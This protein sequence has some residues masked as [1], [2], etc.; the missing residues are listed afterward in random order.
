M[1][2]R[3]RLAP[4]FVLVCLLAPGAS[5]AQA[6]A[7]YSLSVTPGPGGTIRSFP[8]G[9]DCGGSGTACAADFPADTV[10]RLDALED[11]DYRFASWGGACRGVEQP[12]C[13]VTM[14]APK[15]V[16]AT[17]A[18]APR[19]TVPRTAI[20]TV[21]RRGKGTVR[22][23]PVGINC[24]TVCFASYPHRGEGVLLTLTAKASFRSRFIG[25]SGECRG[26]A[27]TC[28]LRVTRIHNVRAQFS[29]PR[30]TVCH[31]G[32][33]ISVPQ[34]RVRAHRRHGDKLG[35]CRRR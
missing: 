2:E 18:P 16:D 25:W 9:I 22:S 4:L 13:P 34:S 21:I 32:R 24:G 6:P 1:R 12:T 31:R 23:S 30:V 33:T 35:R 8:A 3:L 14:N 29:E 10:V 15:S 11:T 20:L 5:S 27:A 19:Q 26:R 17:F 28:T 7:T